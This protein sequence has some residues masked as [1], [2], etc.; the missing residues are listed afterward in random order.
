MSKAK[1]NV[2][3]ISLRQADTPEFLFREHANDGLIQPN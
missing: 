2:G 3:A 1:A